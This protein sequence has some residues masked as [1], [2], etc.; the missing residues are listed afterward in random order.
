M[1]NTNMNKPMQQSDGDEIFFHIQNNA[2]QYNIQSAD[3]KNQNIKMIPDQVI[4]SQT[5]KPKPLTFDQIKLV[6]ST[7]VSGDGHVKSVRVQCPQCKQKVDTVIIRKP[8]TQT[9]LASC[10]LLLCSFGLVCVSCLPCII[11]DC[12]DVLHSCPQ[13]KSPLGKTQFKILD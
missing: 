6:S 3:E 5:T 8:G 1:S 10:I 7:Q 12:K 11:D 2:E 4:E 13:C 9:Y